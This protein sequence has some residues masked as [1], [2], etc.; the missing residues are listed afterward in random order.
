MWAKI[1]LTK[2]HLRLDLTKSWEPR[3]WSQKVCFL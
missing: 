2:K 3:G 1:I